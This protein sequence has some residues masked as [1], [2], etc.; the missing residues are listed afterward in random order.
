MNQDTHTYPKI[1]IITPSYNQ[2]AFI[3]RT[4]KSVL[5]QN[6]SNLE[7]IIVDGGSTDN[8]VEIIKKYQD[9]IH[10][11]ISERDKG[12]YE[13]NNKALE[14]VTGDFWC[15]VNSDDLLAEG[16]LEKIAA[17]IQRNPESKWF[18]GGIDYIDENDAV[19]GHFIPE[20]PEAVNGFTFIDGCWISHP[21]VFLSSDLINTIGKFEKYHLMDLNYW[22]RMELQGYSPFIVHTSLAALRLHKDSKSADRIKLHAEFLKVLH[23]FIV[24]NKLNRFNA[25]LRT[26][27]F[28]VRNYMRVVF[29]ETLVTGNKK[30][31]WS[32]FIDLTVKFPSSI[33]TRWYWGGV[34]R[35]M[36]GVSSTDLLRKDFFEKENNS[37]WN[38]LDE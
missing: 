10:Y 14:K 13:A 9:K 38:N 28:H 35:L 20:K 25:I 33:V 12:T 36:L 34:K 18:A 5:E 2:G 4:I 22:L 3:E 15:V 31:A 17:H 27:N 29:Y 23:T 6:Y 7:Y 19:T 37:N 26:Y 21:A 1:S 11:W 24:Q 32:Q 16:A 30:S 8:T